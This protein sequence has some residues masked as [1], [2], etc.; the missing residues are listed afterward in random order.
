MSA[1][2][3]TLAPV[4]LSR[5]IEE[6][7]G[8]GADGWEIY[9][10]SRAMIAEGKRVTQLTIGDHDVPPHGR[11]LDALC[12]SAR[13]GHTGY[14]PVEGVR[15]LRE[16]IAARVTARTAVPA[17]VDNVAVSAGGQAGLF[18]AMMA[19]MDAGESCV[20]LDPYYATYAQT[21]RAAGGRA[22]AVACPAEGG[23]QPNAA[24]IEAAL[25]PDT[26]AILINTPNNPTGAVYTP[27]ALTALAELCQRRGLWLISD[28]VYDSQVWEGSHLSPRDLPGMA[29]R[30][31][32]VNSASKA[33]GVTGFRLGWAVA[34]EPVAA[35][36]WDLAIATSY[37]LPGFVQ[38]AVLAGLAADCP[39]EA[40]IVTRYRT[41]R[42]AG[43]AALA[44]AGGPIRV[45]PP[46]GGMYLLLDV[47][48]TGLSGTGFATRLL[49]ETG[50]AVMPGESFGEAAAGHV[51]VALTVPEEPLTEALGRLARFAA[52][53]SAQTL[54]QPA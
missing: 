44:A 39:A 4:R 15:A 2:G 41:R 23:F 12:D 7:V 50:I 29:D 17:G 3:V 45:S 49:E 48:A 11:L 14:T 25:E 6:V 28:E 16:A 9:Y 27:E 33:L 1:N 36:L 32:V 42:A 51:R 8:G 47:R 21:V 38:D 46:Q 54:P 13:G 34:P 18:A 22:I 52:D 26:R 24:A 40:E 20:V 53:L 43:L 5:R 37:G 19:V 30:V 31:I 35:R 10:M